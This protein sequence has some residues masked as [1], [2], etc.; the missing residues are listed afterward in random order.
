MWVLL[1]AG[2]VDNTKDQG[3]ATPAVLDGRYVHDIDESVETEKNAGTQRRRPI[4][5]KEWQS[6]TGPH[7]KVTETAVFLL[8]VRLLESSNGPRVI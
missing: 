2:A 1:V 8:T 7:P 6:P 5:E 3:F 4:A